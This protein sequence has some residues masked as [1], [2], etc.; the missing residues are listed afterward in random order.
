MGPACDPQAGLYCIMGYGPCSEYGCF[1]KQ[2]LQNE[3]CRL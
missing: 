3:N 2:V 1:Y